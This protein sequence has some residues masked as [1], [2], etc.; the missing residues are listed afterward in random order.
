MDDHDSII[1]GREDAGGRQKLAYGTLTESTP[2]VFQAPA[3]KL[4]MY[5]A[6][7]TA[8]FD[9]GAVTVFPARRDLVFF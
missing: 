9:A 8:E 2:P 6:H 5:L 3:T 7:L 1:H 4:S